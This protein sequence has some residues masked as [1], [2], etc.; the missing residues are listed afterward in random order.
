MSRT[1][2]FI[3]KDGS[4]VAE[5]MLTISKSEVDRL[6]AENA[7]LALV[8]RKMLLHYP[9]ALNGITTEEELRAALDAARKEIK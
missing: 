9:A 1:R 3:T 7:A 6:V 2:F 5:Q 8:V 4:L